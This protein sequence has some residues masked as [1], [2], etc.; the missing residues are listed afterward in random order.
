ML[1]EKQ[2]LTVSDFDE[3]GNPAK[4]K[5]I[6]DLISSYSPYENLGS[7]E[8]PAVLVVCGSDD[9]R[10]PLWNVLKYVQKFRQ[11]VN[12]PLRTVEIHDKNIFVHSVDS[13]HFGEAS[14]SSGL[15]EKSTYL[16]FL[17]FILDGKRNK[18]IVSEGGAGNIKV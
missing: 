10:A 12:S 17:D 3:F 9:Y 18:D 16:A 13:G 2:P 6:Y 15:K 14:V 7:H 8:Y 4:D 5:L 11:R 1:D